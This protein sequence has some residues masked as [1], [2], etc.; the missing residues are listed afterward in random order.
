MRIDAHGFR[1][2]LPAPWEGAVRLGEAS[3]TAHERAA[4]QG[5]VLQTPP[6]L[7]LSTTQMPSLRGD[8]G[9]G[10]VDL[11]GTEDVFVAVLEYGADSVGTPLFDTGP[12]PRSLD[13]RAFAGNGLQ[14][15]IPGQAGWQHFCTENG[16]ALCLYVVLGS[17]HNARRLV[18]TADDVL[19]R[20]EI[21]PR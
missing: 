16:R 15:A 9:S 2:D 4:F 3:R 12:L 1:V 14:R 6:V 17:R 8:F 19:S 7:H 11:L 10:A 5:R 21:A 20:L 13:H 18:R